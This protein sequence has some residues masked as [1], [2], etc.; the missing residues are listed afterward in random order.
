LVEGQVTAVL[1]LADL[2]RGVVGKYGYGAGADKS[3]PDPPP[4]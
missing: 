1:A 2:T 3:L 4:R